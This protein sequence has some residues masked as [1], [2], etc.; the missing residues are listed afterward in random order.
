MNTALVID[1]EI[2]EEVW[3]R[4]VRQIDGRVVKQSRE[5]LRNGVANRVANRVRNT[6]WLP[7]AYDDVGRLVWDQADEE[8]P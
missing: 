5:L 8:V 2:C 6:L 4:V 1:S 7:R 3:Q